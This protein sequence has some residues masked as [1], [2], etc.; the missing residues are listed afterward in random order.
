MSKTKGGANKFTKEK[1]TRPSIT[2][3]TNSL[4]LGGSI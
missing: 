1:K 4:I 2:Y 3:I